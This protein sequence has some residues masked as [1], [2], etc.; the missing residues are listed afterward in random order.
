MNTCART[1]QGF[2]A[3]KLIAEL[4]FEVELVLLL[5]TCPTATTL[6][7]LHPEYGDP[8]YGYITGFNGILRL[9]I[10][11]LCESGGECRLGGKSLRERERE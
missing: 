6:G 2:Q 10:E 1:L 7:R 3:C 5:P 9:V 11:G 8:L 4:G